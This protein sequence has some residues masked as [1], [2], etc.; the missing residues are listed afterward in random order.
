MKQATPLIKAEVPKYTPQKN[1][2]KGY[3]TPLI[4]FDVYKL[5]Y[6]TQKTRI[7]CPLNFIKCVI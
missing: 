2:V 5:G 3:A 6:N 7:A 4:F 1:T